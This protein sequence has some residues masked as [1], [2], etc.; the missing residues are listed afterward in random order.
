MVIFCNMNEM[1]SL[2][3]SE[4]KNTL[5]LRHLYSSS[6]DHL[7]LSVGNKVLVRVEQS[8]ISL[9]YEDWGADNARALVS[10]RNYLQESVAGGTQ[11]SN[12]LH[13]K[14]NL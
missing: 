12:Y 1:I 8:A 5:L 14:P 11:S 7:I 6:V 10:A 13:F 4:S 9:L 3:L 2:R